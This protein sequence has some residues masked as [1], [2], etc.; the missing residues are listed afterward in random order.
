MPIIRR[1]VERWPHL[2]IVEFDCD[3]GQELP[4][5]LH[6]LINGLEHLTFLS[7]RG[8]EGALKSTMSVNCKLYPRWTRS[9][10]DPNSF[11]RHLKV[12]SLSGSEHCQCFSSLSNKYSIRTLEVRAFHFD[13]DLFGYS[14]RPLF[15][16]FSRALSREFRS[17]ER[18]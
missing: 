11:V 10:S 18:R 6:T 5:L 14:H 12:S 8:S 15:L 13:T 7:V 3:D 2:Q 1:I 17:E 16:V 4:H 9:L